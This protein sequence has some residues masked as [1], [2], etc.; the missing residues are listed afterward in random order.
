MEIH[1]LEVEAEIT[2]E[3]PEVMTMKVEEDQINQILFQ[4]IELIE[5]TQKA[6]YYHNN[7]LLLW[8]LKYI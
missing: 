7:N 4:M 1:H 2:L 6:G 3:I 8:S 5:M